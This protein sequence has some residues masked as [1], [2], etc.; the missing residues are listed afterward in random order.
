MAFARKRSRN[1]ADGDESS[2]FDSIK[3]LS[4]PISP[5][6]KKFRQSNIQKSPW[7]LT[8]IRDLPDE[9][10]KDTVSL[11]DLLS[12]PLIL[13]CWQFNFLHDIPFVMNAFDESVRDSIRLHV[14]HGFWK[15]SD[16]NRIHLSDAASRYPNVAL[17]C[18]PM[19]EMFGTHH[20]KM[21]ILFRADNTAQIIIHTANMIPKDWT[22]MTNAVWKSPKLPLSTVPDIIS[23]DGQTLPVG[24]GLRFKADLLS[25]LMKYDSYKV[26]CKPLA[27]HLGHFDFSSIRAAFIASV[28]GKHGFRNASQPA[29]G[30]AGL[31]RC[32]QGVPVEPGDSTIVVQISSIATLGAQNDW[33][34]RTLFDSLATSLTRTNRPSFKVI[35]PTADEIRNSLD[36]YASGNSIHTK[37]QSAQHVSQLSYLHPMLHHWANDSK[38]G[39][40]IILDAPIRGDGGRNRAAPHIK[41]YIRFNRN[42]EIDWAMLTSANMSKQAWGETLKP[43]STGEFRIASWEVGVLVWPGLFCKDGVMLSSF[44]SDTVDMSSQAQ[45]PIVSLRIPYSMPLQAYERREV[46]WAATAA[47]PEPDR[48]GVMWTYP[49]SNANGNA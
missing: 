2:G 30:W 39:A 28:P 15:R 41:T 27:D 7:Q 16:L 21:M 25:Y 5:P 32:L 14:V 29:W 33:L 48:K 24:S 36:G 31:Q 46:P 4:R 8:R 12:D 3:S 47:H 19:P 35:F 6:R 26:I 49:S 42:T 17:H 22:N 1:G 38:D 9:V 43:N 13:E 23:Q 11:Q 40:K 18:A 10:N 37:I 44:Q 20:S 45:R 34:Q